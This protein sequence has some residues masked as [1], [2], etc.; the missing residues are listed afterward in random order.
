MDHEEY[1]GRNTPKDDPDGDRERFS[2]GVIECDCAICVQ[3]KR[4]IEE[5]QALA[6]MYGT[7]MDATFGAL[8]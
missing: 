6:E 7:A 1:E 5:Q 4:Y 3:D 2:I 8:K